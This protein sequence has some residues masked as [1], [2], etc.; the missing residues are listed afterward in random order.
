MRYIQLEKGES[1][2]KNEI[3]GIF[4]LESA[5]TSQATKELFSPLTSDAPKIF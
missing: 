2:D 3:I 4:D 1:I 5:S